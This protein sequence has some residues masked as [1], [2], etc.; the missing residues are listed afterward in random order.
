MTPFITAAIIA[1]GI[2]LA[3][4][5]MHLSITLRR[6]EAAAGLLF[7][8]MCFSAAV[9]AML[10]AAVFQVADPAAF[11]PLFKWQA[12]VQGIFWTSLT[13]FVVFRT[14]CARRWLAWAVTGAFA[15]ALVVN[16]ASP[17]GVF[18]LAIEP[19]PLVDLPWGERIAY[20]TG[21]ANPLRII[22]DIGWCLMLWLIGGKRSPSPPQRAAEGGRNPGGR[23]DSLGRDRLPPRHPGPCRH[24][25]SAARIELCLSRS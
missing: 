12:G 20:A 16:M 23:G 22:A 10:D 1:S 2:C 11:V 7:A 9:N 6:R 15:L 21:E 5:I 24:C 25:R 13:W 3:A 4:G 8:V 14:G 19:L 17:A 18:F